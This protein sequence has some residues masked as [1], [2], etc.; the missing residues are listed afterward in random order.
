MSGTFEYRPKAEVRVV[1]GSS[2]H[3]V[4]RKQYG[5]LST[6]WPPLSYICIL[7]RP[8]ASTTVI[9]TS[10]WQVLSVFDA[11]AAKAAFRPPSISVISELPS[12][13]QRSWNG[14]RRVVRT[15]VRGRERRHDD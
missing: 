5:Y 7:R 9:K 1:G 2:Y 6:A 12:L 14:S 4:V 13:N 15:I 3:I 10:A 11:A 8:A